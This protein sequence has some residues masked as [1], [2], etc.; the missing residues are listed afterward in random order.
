[1]PH[2]LRWAPGCKRYGFIDS[3]SLWVGT[4]GGEIAT[5]LVPGWVNSFFWRPDGEALAIEAERVACG[6][7]LS[8]GSDISRSDTFLAQM[9]TLSI[10][11][12]SQD[13]RTSPLGWSS[14]GTRVLLAR[15]VTYALPCEP[16]MG[17]CPASDI[18]ACEAGSGQCK[19]LITQRRL[20]EEHKDVS[21]LI[22]WNAEQHVLYVRS[23]DLNFGGTGR[24]LALD[25]STARTLRSF[26]AEAAHYLGGGL[27]GIQE[28]IVEDPD[29]GF[30]WK[31]MIL[32]EHGPV[33]EGFPLL[34]PFGW[35]P[36]GLWMNTGSGPSGEISFSTRTKANVWR[37]RLPAGFGACAYGAWTARDTAVAVGYEDAVRQG[38]FAL[39]LWEINPATERAR[40]LMQGDAALDPREPYPSIMACGAV[41]F[42]NPFAPALSVATWDPGR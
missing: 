41:T 3:G 36:S 38:R 27:I 33:L 24:L 1:L 19:V 17:G 12:V 5:A 42:S 18:L 34:G 4:L 26:D 6:G 10:K 31:P 23:L 40:L 21:E 32:N 35:S 25:E 30:V 22:H 20:A 11:P 14:D 9:P 16:A 39:Q 15:Q 7:R 13:C 2:D 37:F 29:Q 8:G 28:R